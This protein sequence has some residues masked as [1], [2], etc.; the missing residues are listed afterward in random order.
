LQPPQTRRSPRPPN[1][2]L[3]NNTD[4]SAT[5]NTASATNAADSPS[6]PA[7]LS[8]KR[9]RAAARLKARKRAA[10]LNFLASISLDGVYGENC[11]SAAADADQLDNDDDASSACCEGA[12]TAICGSEFVDDNDEFSRSAVCSVV[13]QD[14]IAGS[15][16]NSLESSTTAAAVAGSLSTRNPQYQHYHQQQHSGGH[17]R[18]RR[19]SAD[20]S[21][22]PLFVEVP[23][24]SLSPPTDAGVV[25]AVRYRTQSEFRAQLS[26]PSGFDYSSSSRRWSRQ[27]ADRSRTTSSS[28]HSS[29]SGPDTMIGS[30]AQGSS[31]FGRQAASSTSDR[32]DGVVGGG[33][34]VE[35]IADLA[36]IIGGPFSSSNGSRKRTRTR[37]FRGI[38]SFFGRQRHKSSSVST[39]TDSITEF[40]ISPPK[41]V[42]RCPPTTTGLVV[43]KDRLSERCVLVT[44]RKSPFYAF[45][46]VKFCRDSSANASRSDQPESRLRHHSSGS[47][48]PTHEILLAQ[49]G[50]LPRFEENQSV[51]YGHLLQPSA[52]RR[53]RESGSYKRYLSVDEHESYPPAAN[54]TG[55]S[56]SPIKESAPLVVYHPHLLDNP[57]L[58]CGKHMTVLNFTSYVTSVMEYV[59]PSD[60]KKD[61]NQ[62]FRERFP[63]IQLT[64]S[65]LRS[66][67]ADLHRIAKKSSM[68]LW[69]LAQSFVFF[70]KLALKGLINK[71]NRKCCCAA[72]LVLSAKLN[73]VKGAELNNLFD[74]LETAFRLTKREILLFEL[75]IL[76]GLEFSL[77]LPD[78]EISPHLHRLETETV[79]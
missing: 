61:L 47:V 51:S 43:K 17:H 29:L 53:R 75:P 42:Y 6:N 54:Q 70:E 65:K 40:P 24:Q 11:A 9:L 68:D 2:P 56:I 26:V 55:L 4:A 19:Q 10:A 35:D 30:G 21:P 33:G 63:Q 13:N 78:Y 25:V 71:A 7:R 64:L 73:D 12:S 60:L 46:I 66:L 3:S 28:N 18:H 57:D 34:G 16:A 76:V 15:I 58:T 5:S 22:L 49:F 23:G 41:G 74:E 37:S 32:G 27:R 8:S 79:R 1:L 52:V 62:Q 44:N 67:K 39:S 77:V 36:E 50:V 69:T 59:R 48:S 20:Q 31:I 72:S 38:E 14:E 45:S